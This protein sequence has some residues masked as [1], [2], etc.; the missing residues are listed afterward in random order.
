[1]RLEQHKFAAWLRA[2]PPETIVG[3][4]RDCHCCPIAKFYAEICGGEIVIF[5]RLGEGYFIDRGYDA[6]LAPQ[7]AA[8]FISS[9]DG[10]DNGK[11]TARRAL[12]IL[13]D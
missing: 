7:W 6:R 12:E 2:K 3:E 11:I 1:M 10:D 4:N 13:T 5:E 8:R 9:V